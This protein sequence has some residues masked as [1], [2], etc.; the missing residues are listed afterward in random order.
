MATVSC[1]TSSTRI[2]IVVLLPCMVWMISPDL[3]FHIHSPPYNQDKN[4]LFESD[5]RLSTGV[6]GSILSY[7]DVAKHQAGA[8][9]T[10]AARTT[11]PITSHIMRHFAKTEPAR[12]PTY[13]IRLVLY[14]LIAEAQ[15]RPCYSVGRVRAKTPKLMT[16]HLR[17]EHR[18]IGFQNFETPGKV[19]RHSV[20]P[21][22]ASTY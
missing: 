19:P 7:V 13:P 22:C 11:T 15:Q 4:I 17:P 14:F 9:V 20:G 21:D 10:L 3:W 2:C 6:A 12:W 5:V 18:P 1:T 16:H 8:I